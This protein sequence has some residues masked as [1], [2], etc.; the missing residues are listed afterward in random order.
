MDHGLDIVTL[1]Q[2]V[3]QRAVAD[4]PFDERHF[5][6][7]KRRHTRKRGFAG[8]GQVV[9]HQHLMAGLHERQY[10]MRPDVACT[11]RDQNHQSSSL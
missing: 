5:T 6:P 7:G 10:R 2:A 1:E 11:T 4:I 9:Q 3:E 8:I